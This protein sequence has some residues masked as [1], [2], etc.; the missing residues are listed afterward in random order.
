MA[1][2]HD[3]ELARNISRQ[4]AATCLGV[5]AAC[6]ALGVLAKKS[7]GNQNSSLSRQGS[8]AGQPVGRRP[9]TGLKKKPASARAG[10]TVRLGHAGLPPEFHA[11]A[12]RHA[13]ALT[14]GRTLAATRQGTA[15]SDRFFVISISRVE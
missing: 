9:K 11:G 3:A 10:D 7:G 1:D 2:Q 13:R 4:R 5:L 15:I 6:Q 14:H 12:R 8:V